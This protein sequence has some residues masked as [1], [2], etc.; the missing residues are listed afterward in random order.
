MNKDRI[1]NI[2]VEWNIWGKRK[3]KGIER[4]MY[5]KKIEELVKNTNQVI[6]ITGVRR[7]G[8]STIIRQIAG[9]F[10]PEETLIINLEDERFLERNNTLLI[11]A[12]D[13]YMEK[14]S[15]K[16]KPYVFLD[17][18]QMVPGWERFVRGMHERNA[19][20][21]IVSGSS[22]KIISPELAGLLSGRHLTFFIHPLSFIEFLQ[23]KNIHVKNEIDIIKEK[24]LIK[25]MVREYMEYG[26]FPEVVLLS[27]KERILL[28]YFETLI[29]RDI[30]DRFRVREKEKLNSIAK[31]Y[32]TNISSMISFNRIAKFMNISVATVERF[33]NHLESANLIFFIKKFSFSMKEQEKAQRKVYSVDTG[34]SNIIG[35]RFRENLGKIAENV[36]GLN[37]KIKQAFDP[38]IEIYYWRDYQQREVDF[39]VKKGKDIIQLIQVCWN[40]SDIETKEREI[41]SLLRAMEEFNL[42]ESIII[43]EDQEGEE[44]IK[45]K[46]IKFVPLWK[47]LLLDV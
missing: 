12:F 4:E 6:C 41:R 18:I 34:L 45:G 5:R 46:K 22:S 29:G 27:E 35:F 13:V 32:L 33:S 20:H 39:V 31:Y 37:L 15:A 1:F 2:L 47:W 14:V 30:V 9:Q 3:D 23:F 26:G 8:K 36:V 42:K 21:I 16:D 19:A 10:A 38:G 40:I 25:A 24:N 43:T 11:D 17:E 28:S 44:D 7:S